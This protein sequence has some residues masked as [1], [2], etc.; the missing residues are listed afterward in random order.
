MKNNFQQ[1][2][3]EDEQDFKDKNLNQVIRSKTWGNLSAFRFIGDIVEVY[4][5]RVVD[6]F[7]LIAGGHDDG[8]KRSSTPP[9]LGKA[10]GPSPKKAPGPVNDPIDPDRTDE[11][12]RFDED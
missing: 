1:L 12:D 10:P 6:L 11:I 2:Q 8:N 4:L 3:D 9:S 5:A 7:I